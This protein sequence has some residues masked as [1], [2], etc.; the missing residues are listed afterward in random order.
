MYFVDIIW[1]DYIGYIGVL[2]SSARTSPDQKI[3]S[4]TVGL[5]TDEY[6][7][8]VIVIFH[9]FHPAVCPSKRKSQFST[10]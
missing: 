5:N 3:F 4:Y 9:L 8:K 10:N 7:D 2:K 6:F 1:I